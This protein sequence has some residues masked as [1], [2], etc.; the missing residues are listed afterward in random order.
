MRG[1]DRTSGA[2]F[3]YVDMEARIPAKHPLLP[4]GA[5]LGADKN[6]DVE[7]FVEGLKGGG[8]WLFI[9]DA[10]DFVS[11]H[12]AKMILASPVKALMVRRG[13]RLDAKLGQYQQ[14]GKLWGKCGSCAAV[15]WDENELPLEPL[16][17]NPPIYHE[18]CERRHYLLP[19]L[20][21]SS[22]WSWQFLE[23]PLVVYLVN[24]GSNQSD[25]IVRDTLKWRLYFKLQKWKPWTLAL[26]EEF[27]SLSPP[28][29]PADAL[30]P[31][32]PD[33][34]DPPSPYSPGPT[35]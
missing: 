22:G 7:A 28:I 19:T 1:E 33:P 15:R 30:P 13:Y 35:R 20:F 24:H 23:A 27:V 4:E 6:Y 26:D 34:P 31:S 12:L 14:L 21:A 8:G 2:L 5:T 9:L 16:S 11:K 10:D 17:D 32:P 25:V 18:F 3:S 29:P